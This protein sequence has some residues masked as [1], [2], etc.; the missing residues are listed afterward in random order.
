MSSNNLGGRRSLDNVAT[1][2]DEALHHLAHLFEREVGVLGVTGSGVGAE[3]DCVAHKGLLIAI[4]DEANVGAVKQALVV[5]VERVAPVVHLHASE[6]VELAELGDVRVVL[7]GHELHRVFTGVQEDGL[8]VALAHS[9]GAV[10]TLWSSRCVL[11]RF[12]FE[13]LLRAAYEVNPLLSGE[14]FFCPPELVGYRR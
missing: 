7:D 6:D 11:S 5:D 13:N 2:A 10:R 4:D 8:V 1:K 9:G 14:L 3:D 12:I